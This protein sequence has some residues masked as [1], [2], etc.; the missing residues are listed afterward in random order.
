[1]TD[2]ELEKG[3]TITHLNLGESIRWTVESAVSGSRA[4]QVNDLIV[5]PRDI[6]LDRHDRSSDLSFAVRERRRKNFSTM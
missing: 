4:E 2:I 1:V 3:E 6:G 5:K